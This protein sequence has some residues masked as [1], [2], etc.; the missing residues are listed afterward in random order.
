[1]VCKMMKP[2][3]EMCLQ[4]KNGCLP[5]LDA[6]VKQYIDYRRNLDTMYLDKDA[7]V[8]QASPVNVARAEEA[9][10]TILGPHSYW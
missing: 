5:N 7:A 8:M 2:V 3:W 4:E 10:L 1:M 9:R 6:F